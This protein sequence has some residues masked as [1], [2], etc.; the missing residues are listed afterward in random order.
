MHNSLGPGDLVEVQRT[1]KGDLEVYN[2]RNPKE[3]RGVSMKK[4]GGSQ[5]ASAEPGNAGKL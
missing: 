4:G 1:P 3:R 5:L 2:P